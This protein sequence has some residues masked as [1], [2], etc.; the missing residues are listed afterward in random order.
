MRVF[1]K[2]LEFCHGSKVLAML[3][4]VNAGL[5]LLLTALIL[6]SGAAGH[7]LDP[8]AWLTLPGSLSIFIT[9][10]WTL[11]TYM[12]VQFDIL[13][14]LFNVL[15]LY[16]FGIILLNTLDERHLLYYY[17]GG[18]LSGGVL[19]LICATA[20]YGG[21]WLCGCSA[22]VLSVMAG[23]A[24]RVPD[25]RVNLFLIGAVKLKWIALVCGL[26]TLLGGG[27]NQAA[28]IGGIVFGLVFA[29]ILKRPE[30]WGKKPIKNRRDAKRML[31]AIER[32]RADHERLDQLL[33]KIKI[34]GYES[35]SR[36]EKK[37]LMDLSSR[38]KR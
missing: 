29:F 37:E 19:F 7:T 21:G 14:L 18:G 28:H 6:I 23:A 1:E 11:A 20:G 9:R 12:F 5:W 36:R 17:G 38:L 35:L 2:I 27:G 26:L 16:W 4:S 30:I 22:A 10:P 31:S 3:V 8:S 13:H 15:W 24:V 34:S 25:H 32:Q 33:D